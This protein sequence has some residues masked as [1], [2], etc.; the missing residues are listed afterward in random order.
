MEQMQNKADKL[1]QRKKKFIKKMHEKTNKGQ[2][3]MSNYV[4]YA[5]TKL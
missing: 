1:K 3:V 4:K 2:P 5:L